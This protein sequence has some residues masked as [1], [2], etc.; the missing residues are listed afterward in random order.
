LAGIEIEKDVNM[1][2]MLGYVDGALIVGRTEANDENHVG[3]PRGIITPRSDRWTVKNVDFYNFNFDE[4]AALGSCSHC[5]HA[6]ATDSD[7]RT[8][9]FE[10][11]YMDPFSVERKIRSQFPHKFIFLDVDG[12]WN[13]KGPGSWATYYNSE[14]NTN[15]YDGKHNLV[16]PACSADEEVYDGIICDNSVTIRRVVFYNMSPGNLKGKNLFVLPYDDDIIGG[17]SEEEIMAY[18]AEGDVNGTVSYDPLNNPFELAKIPFR[19]KTNPSNHYAAPFVT[20]HKYYLRW[21][22]VLDFEEMRI[23]IENWLWD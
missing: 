13:E 20:G 3:S 10:N 8:V 1:E 12:S 14:T 17:L 5:F 15:A 16:D 9:K 23:G 19:G 2:E 21:N 6:A 7:C 11:I 4:A 18:E 22:A